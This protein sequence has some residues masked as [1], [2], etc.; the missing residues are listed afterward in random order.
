MHP[1]G[2][3]IKRIRQMN[4]FPLIQEIKRP[5]PDDDP[6]MGAQGVPEFKEG[7]LSYLLPG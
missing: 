5:V 2:I 1:K 3:L 6:D 4:D 7:H